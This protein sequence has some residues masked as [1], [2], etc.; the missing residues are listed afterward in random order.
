MT[1]VRWI[2]LIHTHNP[3]VSWVKNS[4]VLKPDEFEA[5]ENVVENPL[6]RVEL[7]ATTGLAFEVSQNFSKCSVFLAARRTVVESRLLVI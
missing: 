7:D 6:H 3:K 5:R 4:V 1:L 2:V